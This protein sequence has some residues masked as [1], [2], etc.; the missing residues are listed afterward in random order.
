[1]SSARIKGNFTSADPAGHAF[2]LSSRSRPSEGVLGQT[3]ATTSH[4]PTSAQM[5]SSGVTTDGVSVSS[6][7]SGNAP[8]APDGRH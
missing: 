6:D 2:E 5:L 7:I 8:P 3:A 4:G 1:V